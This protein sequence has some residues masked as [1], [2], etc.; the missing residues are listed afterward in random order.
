[1]RWRQKQTWGEGVREGLMEEV[2]V[3]LVLRLQWEEDS[4]WKNVGR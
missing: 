4:E 1:M 2:K 3:E